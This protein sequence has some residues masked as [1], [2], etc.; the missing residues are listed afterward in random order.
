MAAPAAAGLRWEFVEAAADRSRASRPEAAPAAPAAAAARY[1][2]VSAV[3]PCSA[4]RRRQNS[5]LPASTRHQRCH[6]A[7][8]LRTSALKP[9][10][11][12]LDPS[13]PRPRVAHDSPRAAAELQPPARSAASKD[14]QKVAR[15][16]LAAAT[17]RR[18][19]S[20]HAAAARRPADAHPPWATGQNHVARPAAG[21]P[22]AIPQ[23]AAPATPWRR[24]SAALSVRSGRAAPGAQ[25]PP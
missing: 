24:P 1:L 17:S 9:H 19:D 18:S 20:S 13:I 12:C 25:L 7:A 2:P 14:Q 10:P 8:D 5:G 6:S 22:L 16:S 11:A 15:T 21:L 3:R 4:D 23:N